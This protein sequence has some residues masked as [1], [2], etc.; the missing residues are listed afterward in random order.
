MGPLFKATAQ[1]SHAMEG[2]GAGAFQSDNY[3]VNNKQSCFYQCVGCEGKQLAGSSEEL[4][5]LTLM[6]LLLKRRRRE[7][8]Y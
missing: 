1:V 6:V 7:H 8:N 5:Q 4:C 2:H 3:F